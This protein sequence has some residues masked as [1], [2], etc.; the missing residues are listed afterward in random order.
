M[1]ILALT[2][3]LAALQGCAGANTLRYAR[4]FNTASAQEE[5]RMQLLCRLDAGR[6]S[7]CWGHEFWSK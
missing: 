7:Q 3:L 5:L 2:M 1:R 6:S 4:E